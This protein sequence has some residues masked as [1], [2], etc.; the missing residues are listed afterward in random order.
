MVAAVVSAAGV[1]PRS[2]GKPEPAMFTVAARQV[3]STRPLAIGDR[4]DTDIAGGIAAEMDTLC[5]LTGVS[6][7]RD[8]L[9]TQHRPTWIAANLV[10]QFDGW[11]ARQESGVIVVE[12]GDTGES[13]LADG[14][15][16]TR[17]LPSGAPVG[18]VMAA[19]ALAAAAPLMWAA[20]DRGECPK[21][22]A[23][24]SDRAASV[25]LEWWR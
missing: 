23:A 13:A 18:E 4:L 8:I 2:A 22:I 1:T 3:G 25:A 12:S 6:T 11:T 19:A 5:V 17:L 20:E 16:V 21:V 10:D 15:S 7:H 14:D 24:E 9:H